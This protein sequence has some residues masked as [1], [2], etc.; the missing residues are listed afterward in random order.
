[1]KML[2]TLLSVFL[3]HFTGSTQ[4]PLIKWGKNVKIGW[5]DF[6]GKA[7]L[8]SP[9]AAVSAVG[10]HYKYNSWSDGKIYKIRFEIFA[11]FDKTKSWS[12]RRLQTESMLKHEQLHFDIGGLVA[13]EFKKDAE[14]RGYSRNYRNEIV[15]MFNRYLKSLQK[16]QQ[17][18]DDQTNHSKNKMKQKE[19]GNLVGQ[20]LF[21]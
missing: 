12:K 20:E 7:D 9:F 21:K 1:M 17:K 3:L 8:N 18:Y 4:E 10:I 19:W 11:T 15:E 16:L 13:R 14:N 5:P 2:F 6:K